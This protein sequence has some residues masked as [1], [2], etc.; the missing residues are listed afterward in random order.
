VVFNAIAENSDRR[1]PFLGMEFNAMELIAALLFIG[2]MGKS[3]QFVLAF[4]KALL[5]LCAGSVIHAMHHEQDMRKMGG[6]RKKVPLTYIAMIIGTLA[7]TGIGIPGT[8]IGFA[9]FFSK[10]AIIEAAY[11]AAILGSNAGASF[12]ACYR[13][14]DVYSRRGHSKAHP[15]N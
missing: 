7:I 6:I 11:S 14:Y 4:F 2:A 1:L 15:Y 10:D 3:A 8:K 12:R 5:F 13:L 9:G